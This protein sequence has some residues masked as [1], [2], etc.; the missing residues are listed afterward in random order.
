MSGAR[1]FVRRTFVPVCVLIVLLAAPA[2]AQYVTFPRLGLS[3]APDRYEPNIAVA[4]RDT[5][6]LHVLVLPRQ[7]QTVHEH[8]FTSFH[9]AVLDACCGGAAVILD[10]DYNPAC[11]NDG[12]IFGGFVTTF[13]EC[14]TGEV[15]HLATLRMQMAIDI[16]G[17]YWIIA[18]PISQALT[19]DAQPV[20]MTDLTVYVDYTT[21][22]TPVTA[23]SW[24][25]V[26]ALFD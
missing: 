16:P 18:G 14:V 7:E 24:S 8:S 6:E 22:I 5:F 25:G 11:R 12:D 20:V 3:A 21:D 4:G 2:A 17:V 26:K 13:E 23:A 10:E 15:V 1:S 9:W 19:C